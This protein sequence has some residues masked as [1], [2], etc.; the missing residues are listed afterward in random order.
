MK[1]LFINCNYS[2]SKRQ[3]STCGHLVP[4]LGEELATSY[5]SKS[6]H[7]ELGSIYANIPLRGNGSNQYD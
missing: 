7:Y 1:Q 3:I 4:T 5:A 6:T 2:V